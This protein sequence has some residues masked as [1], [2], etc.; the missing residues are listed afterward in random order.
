MKVKVFA[1]LGTFDA[2]VEPGSKSCVLIV[3]HR[4]ARHPYIKLKKK[5]DLEIDPH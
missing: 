2:K 5:V 3:W 4:V 1:S